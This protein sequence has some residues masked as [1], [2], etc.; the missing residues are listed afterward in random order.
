[1]SECVRE[2]ERERERERERE[3]RETREEKQERVCVSVRD[4]ER[5]ESTR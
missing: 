4:K 3:W 2:G 5:G 1:M